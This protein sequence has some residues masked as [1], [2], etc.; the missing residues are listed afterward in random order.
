MKRTLLLAAVLVGAVS[1]PAPALGQTAPPSPPVPP[2][3][4][5]P[6]SPSQLTISAATD[7]AT[8]HVDYQVDAKGSTARGASLASTGHRSGSCIGETPSEANITFYANGMSLVPQNN[9]QLLPLVGSIPSNQTSDPNAPGYNDLTQSNAVEYVVVCNGVPTGYG[10]YVPGTTVG[11]GGSPAAIR[12]VAQSAA[13]SIAMPN[14]AIEA[15]PPAQGVTGLN[16]WFYAQGYSGGPIST[17]R[18]A[19]GATIMVIATPTSYEWNF[20]DGSPVV[21]SASLG[22]PWQA[23]YTPASGPDCN[24]DGSPIQT[25]NPVIAGSVTHCYNHTSPGLTVSVTFNFA[26]TYSVN[27]GL[28]IALAP[29]QR[30]ATLTYPVEQILSTTVSRS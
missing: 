30:S 21:T 11:N 16:T 23:S 22:V 5:G 27:G 15:N 3:D 28:P 29:I 12:R 10:M 24:F 2:P 8:G 14:V 17:T 18:N 1:L 6:F 7:Q 9:G 19:L 20:G 26:V 25:G 4:F 13:G